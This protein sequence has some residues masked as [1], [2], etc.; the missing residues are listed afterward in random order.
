[1]ATQWA[2]DRIDLTTKRHL[3]WSG[4]KRFVDLRDPAEEAWWIS[5][6]LREGREEDIRELPLG[7]VKELLP[8]LALPRHLKE[9]W[10]AYFR[11]AQAHDK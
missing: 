10:E 1:M 6:V 8:Q 3:Y 4:R 2:T 5:T 9:I 7:R 11:E